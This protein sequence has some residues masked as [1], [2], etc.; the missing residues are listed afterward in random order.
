MKKLIEQYLYHCETRK[1]LNS[2]TLK[3]YRIDLS[4]FVSFAISKDA[5][6][7]SKALLTDYISLLHNTYQPKTVKRKIASLKTFSHYL[8][9][10][11][12]IEMDPFQKIVL[13]Y[14]EPKR[15]PKTI[16]SSTIQLFLTSLYD[17][18]AAAKTQF[19]KQTALRNIA[20]IELLFATGMRISELCS[21]KIEDLDLQNH[22]VLVYG[23]GA[24]ERVIYIGN[25]EVLSLLADYISTCCDVSDSQNW[26][27]LNQRHQR[28]TE[29]SVR[30][31]IVKHAKS[32]GIDLHL[33]PH[34]FRHSFATL[35][36]ESDV[37]IR[38][39]QKIL[40]HSSI[41]TTEIYTQVS[42]H[43]QQ[44]IMNTKHPRNKMRVNRG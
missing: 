16:P 11:D 24:K 27:F 33:T 21:L 29:Q 32:A 22:R 12:L 38:Y 5:D 42:T 40:G 25:T 30:N 41:T 10:E 44:E 17:A 35:L 3:A 8:Y 19:Q 4:Q 18:H 31:M 34:M 1:N 36:L 7:L 14:R 23:K 9:T 28:L 43:K 15:L 39:I 2:K 13:S 26:L 20:V 6:S 37:D